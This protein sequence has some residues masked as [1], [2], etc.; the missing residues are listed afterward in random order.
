MAPLL[1][2]CLLL[3][4]LINTVL[5]WHVF[6][7]RLMAFVKAMCLCVALFISLI[8]NNRKGKSISASQEHNEGKLH[9]N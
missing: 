1:R 9:I 2:A 5:R 4:Q 3:G 6:D 8:V 7:W